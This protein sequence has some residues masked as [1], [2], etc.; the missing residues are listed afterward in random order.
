MKKLFIAFA[1][2]AALALGVVPAQALV[3]MPDD[4]PGCDVLQPFFIASMP[5]FGNTNTLMVF[6]DVGGWWPAKTAPVFHYDVMTKKSVTVYNDVLV[7]TNY[8]IVPTD[9]LTILGLM[10]P[11]ARAQLQVD[12]DGDGINDHWAGYIYFSNVVYANNV[13]SQTLLVN[14]PAGM[15]SSANIPAKEID[16][17]VPPIMISNAWGVELF[18]A[19]A[20]ASAESL[21]IGGGAL[22]ANGFALYPRY[23]IDDVTGKTFLI[24]WK[25]VNGIP[26]PATDIHIMFC[27]EKEDCVSSNIPLPYELNIIDVEQYLPATLHTGYP[28]EGWI[29][30]GVPDIY[31]NPTPAQFGDWEWLGYTWQM[32][33]GG[34][35][36]S[37]TTLTPI[38]REVWWPGK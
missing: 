9:A 3:G 6:T 38:H 15:A 7:G 4:V 17:G 11:T 5:G 36:E 34:A 8:D 10:S 12:L 25:S 2:L 27:N 33:T 26:L 13:I 29:M 16:P 22:G 23:Y 20:L 18:S 1:V 24:I 37:W 14:L 19:N 31:G 35:S 30:I 28:K 21:Q 32:A